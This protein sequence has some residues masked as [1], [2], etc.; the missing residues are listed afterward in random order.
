LGSVHLE[1][2]SK[3]IEEVAA[4]VPKDEV[5]GDR[6][7]PGL[8]KLSWKFAVTPRQVMGTIGQLT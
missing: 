5:A 8:A 4:A 7:H 1:F 6:Y 3:D 2:A